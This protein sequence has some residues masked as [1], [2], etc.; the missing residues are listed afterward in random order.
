MA[1]PK[2]TKPAA[3]TAAASPSPAAA[4]AAQPEP[5]REYR[6]TCRIVGTRD[7]QRHVYVRG[8]LLRLTDAEAKALRTAVKLP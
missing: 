4:A 5:R 7:G 6:A 3:S 8:D 1:D 2:D